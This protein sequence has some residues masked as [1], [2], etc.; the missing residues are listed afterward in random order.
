VIGGGIAGITAAYLL[1]RAGKRVCLLERDRLGAVDT[2][3]T[4]AHLTYVTDVRLTKLVKDF[5]RDGAR[6]AWEGGAAAISTIEEIVRQERIDCDFRRVPGFLHSPLDGSKDEP[7]WA[8]RPAT[9]RACQ[10]MAHRAYGSP[11]RRS[12][13]R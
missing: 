2:G 5:G 4:T 12:S 3:H 11:I 1:K 13:T 9:I 10:S 8:S 6:L 7:S